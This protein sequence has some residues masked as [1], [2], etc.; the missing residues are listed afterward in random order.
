MLQLD[1]GR[2]QKIKLNNTLR[3]N[4][5]LKVQFKDASHVGIFYSIMDLNYA[6][7]EFK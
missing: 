5:K 2:S 4:Y 7:F 6:L 1:P 3:T